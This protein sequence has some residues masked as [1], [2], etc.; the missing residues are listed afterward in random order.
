MRKPGK[1]HAV[2]RLYAELN[3]FL[4][5]SHSQR[6]ITLSFN[7]PVPVRQLIEILGVPHT[8]VELIVVN[9]ESVG[10]DYR[11]CDGDRFNVYPMFEALDISP[12][13]RLRAVPLRDPRFVVDVHLGK[14]NHYLRMLGF[15]AVLDVRWDD[16]ELENIAA[17]QRRILLTRDKGLLMRAGVT[18]GCYIRS[19]QP[20]QQLRY[21]LQ[22]LDLYRLARPF[23]RC[24]ECNGHIEPV[25]KAD[26][27]DRLP[28]DTKHRFDEFWRC[29]ECGRVYWKG[30]HYVRMNRL[31]AQ[32]ME[33]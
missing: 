1:A 6:D 19:P 25:A 10:L 7:S 5:R 15:D 27:R 13:L 11:V 16:A 28:E 21:L 2:F 14:L 4:P 22:R 24:I 26:I 8:D 30:S 20:R 29:S 31:V 9:G 18:H 32:L 23:T 17:T 3:D 33:H 12:L